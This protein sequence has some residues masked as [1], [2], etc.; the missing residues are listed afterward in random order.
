MIQPPNQ[1]EFGRGGGNFGSKPAQSRGGPAPVTA[2]NQ[3]EPGSRIG[4][5][6]MPYTREASPVEGNKMIAGGY[7][8]ARTETRATDTPPARGVEVEGETEP[9]GMLGR[10]R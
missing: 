4:N 3:D 1:G 9:P 5:S 8:G 6:S 10:A 7:A 2:P